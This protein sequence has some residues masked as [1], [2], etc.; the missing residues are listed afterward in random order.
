[1][2]IG[3]S[4]DVAGVPYSSYYPTENSREVSDPFIWIYNFEVLPH[5]SIKVRRWLEGCIP[6]VLGHQT[7]CEQIVT[8][9]RSQNSTLYSTQIVRFR[10][11]VPS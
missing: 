1:M 4:S 9:L 3:S 7:E 11:G 2:K 10:T 5:I 8:P 6:A